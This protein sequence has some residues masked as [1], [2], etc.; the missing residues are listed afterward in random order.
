MLRTE[1]PSLSSMPLPSEDDMAGTSAPW[2]TLRAKYCANSPEPPSA[3]VSSA[4]SIASCAY[5]TEQLR[6]R[7]VPQTDLGFK[8]YLAR[9]S[10]MLTETAVPAGAHASSSLTIVTIK[11]V[12]VACAARVGTH[13]HLEVGQCVR[14]RP[15]GCALHAN[16]TWL[17]AACKRGLEVERCMRAKNA[18]VTS[19]QKTEWL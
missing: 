16:K 4:I 18:C 1:K 5:G 8:F 12:L 9:N 13:D 2:L 6:L 7:A 3:L 14:A 17:G 10:H 11:V 19:S 15:R